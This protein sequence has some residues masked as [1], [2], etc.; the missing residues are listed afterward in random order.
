MQYLDDDST[1]KV[2]FLLT[3][4]I[5]HMPAMVTKRVK[6]LA[7]LRKISNG[8]LGFIVG[9]VLDGKS[10]PCMGPEYRGNETD[11]VAT[12]HE[13]GVTVMRFKVNPSYLL[14]KIRDCKDILVR[15]YPPGIVAI[16]LAGYDCEVKMP[17]AKQKQTLRVYQYPVIPAYAMTPEKLQGVTLH[18]DLYVSELDNRQAQILYVVLSRILMLAWLILTQPLTMEYVRRF[19]PPKIVLEE[20]HKLMNNVHIPVYASKKQREKLTK[21]RAIENQHYASA[22]AIH[23]EREDGRRK[24]RKSFMDFAASLVAPPVTTSKSR[25]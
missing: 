2:P 11:F 13:S 15:G 25:K 23:Q 14:F 1:D 4:H 17:R 18:H 20:V 19:V 3:F 21:W 9:F 22:M 8:L 7:T 16:P 6:E 10:T 12:V 24:Q 5:C